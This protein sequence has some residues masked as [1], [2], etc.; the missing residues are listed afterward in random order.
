MNIVFHNVIN[1]KKLK[2]MAVKLFKRSI[3][4]IEQALNPVNGSKVALIVVLDPTSS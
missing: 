3:F 2:A 1:T 4:E